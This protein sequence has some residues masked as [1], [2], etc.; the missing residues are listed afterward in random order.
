[1]S[2]VEQQIWTTNEVNNEYPTVLPNIDDLYVWI[3]IAYIIL[4]LL[5]GHFYWTLTESEPPDHF[6]EQFWQD[7]AAEF[8]ANQHNNNEPV[9]HPQEQDNND[10]T[11]HHEPLQQPDQPQEQVTNSH[12]PH[13]EPPKPDHDNDTH[14]NDAQVSMNEPNALPHPMEQDFDHY[15]LPKLEIKASVME[16]SFVIHLHLPF[17]IIFL[18]QM[19]RI[20]GCI[21]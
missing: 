14:D 16:E 15:G 12:V 6:E 11:P 4:M 13:N 2:D 9:E 20:Y 1:M 5:T 3:I 21:I 17:L 18:R 19:S 7:Q 8:V 10:N